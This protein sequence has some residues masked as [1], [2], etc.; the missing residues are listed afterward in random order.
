MNPVAKWQKPGGSRNLNLPIAT[1]S[2]TRQGS[3]RRQVTRR[4]LLGWDVHRPRRLSLRCLFD[5][6]P[7]QL[8]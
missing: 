8:M 2:G 5:T 3:R 4:S 7:E 1:E 6:V